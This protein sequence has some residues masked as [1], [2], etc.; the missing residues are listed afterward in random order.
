[1]KARLSSTI[2]L[3]V[4]LTFVALTAVMG[5]AFHAGAQ[6]PGHSLFDLSQLPGSAPLEVLSAL[7]LTL[8]TAFL[9][10]GMLSSRVLKPTEELA[11]FSERLAAGDHR[12]KAEIE[13]HDE[14]GFIAENFN[15]TA[16][17]ISK[18]HL[19]QEAQESLQRSIT[20]LLS[21]I[22]QVARGD[23]TL[24]GKVT[25]DSLSNVVD[26][27]NYM[28]D[29]FSKVLDRVRKAAMEVSGSANNILVAA[30]EMQAGATQQDQETTN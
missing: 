18:A 4:G 2:W 7:V 27:I 12:A 14:Y 8:L 10:G 19:S 6:S 13:S 11:D 20:E 28:L 23:L 22:N 5:L 15:R 26:S 24:R 9:L 29:N 16:G 3:L 21:V 25:N 30:D 17:R 1:M